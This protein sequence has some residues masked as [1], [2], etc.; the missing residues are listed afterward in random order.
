MLQRENI[1]V[2]DVIAVI[3]LELGWHL[4][5]KMSRFSKPIVACTSVNNHYRV[6]NVSVF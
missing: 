5:H 6:C 3:Y 4:T 1:K 2:A